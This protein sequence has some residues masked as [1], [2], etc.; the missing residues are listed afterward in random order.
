M[1]ADMGEQFSDRQ[2]GGAVGAGNGSAGKI[3]DV[4]DALDYAYDINASGIR[5]SMLGSYIILEGHVLHAGDIARA[6][7]IAEDVVGEGKVRSRLVK[8]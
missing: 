2:T 7:E 3:A 6:V 5:V 8:R 1:E 4:S